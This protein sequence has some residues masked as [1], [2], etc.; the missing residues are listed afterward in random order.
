MGVWIERTD[1]K[2]NKHILCIG[3][4]DR[5]NDA[6]THKREEVQDDSQNISLLDWMDVVIQWAVELKRK[7]TFF[8]KDVRFSLAHTE[9]NK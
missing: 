1:S 3:L 6:M 4:G 7:N 9:A 2:N 8:G 5:W